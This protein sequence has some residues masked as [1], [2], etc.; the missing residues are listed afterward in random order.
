MSEE[1]LLSCVADVGRRLSR[2]GATELAT[3]ISKSGS[4]EKL[5]MRRDSLSTIPQQKLAS[6]LAAAWKTS[7]TE[8]A[9]LAAALR[10]A[11]L[12]AELER[13]VETVDLV[14]TGPKTT[15]VPLAKNAEA[16]NEIVDSAEDR[17][18][19]VSYATYDVPKLIEKLTTAVDRGVTVDL[20]LEFHGDKADERQSWD[21]VKGLGGPLPDAVRIWEWPVELREQTG[22]GKV[23]YIHVKCAVADGR[24]AFISSA[25]LTVYAMEMNMEL[26]VIVRGGDL[27]SR[28]AQHF[29]SLIDEGILQR[30]EV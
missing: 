20:V 16:L 13:S 14:W 24:D 30:V 3:V 22:K 10:A 17:L 23:G 15:Q 18:L 4:P 1:A 9:A 29:A 7:D 28:V 27:P 5:E 26:G 12:A 6:E 2:G 19:V 8:G 11:Q 21:P 25:N